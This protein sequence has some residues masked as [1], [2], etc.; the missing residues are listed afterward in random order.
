MS[1]DWAG[2]RIAAACSDKTIK[3]YKKRQEGW[4]EENIIK[5]QGASV[6]K[7]KWARP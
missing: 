1:F 5:I 7:V 2:Q 6:W 4:S 3:I